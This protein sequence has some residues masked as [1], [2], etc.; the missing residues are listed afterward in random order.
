[1]KH[2]LF[3]CLKWF[4]SSQ[5]FPLDDHETAVCMT[6]VTCRTILLERPTF[7]QPGLSSNTNYI[8]LWE[9][10]L[11]VFLRHQI[12]FLSLANWLAYHA[13]KWRQYYPVCQVCYDKRS[14]FRCY[15]FNTFRTRF[16][17]VILLMKLN[18][19]FFFLSSAA[20]QCLLVRIS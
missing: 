9:I 17:Q 20:Q 16:L 19:C 4:H 13:V 8:L 15:M 18:L 3:L 14:L 1:M 11:F 5:L 12:A 6:N 7:S 2:N 10:P